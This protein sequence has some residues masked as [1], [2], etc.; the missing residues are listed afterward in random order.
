MNKIKDRLD[1]YK[2]KVLSGVANKLSDITW[3]IRT[4]LI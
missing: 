1:Y 2:Y 4:N 3:Y